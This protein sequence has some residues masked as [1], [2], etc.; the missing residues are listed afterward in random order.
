MAEITDPD[1]LAILETP[2]SQINKS[3]TLSDGQ[4]GIGSNEAKTR[5][6]QFASTPQLRGLLRDLGRA[7]LFNQRIPTG[8]WKAR[9][10][11]IGQEFPTDWQSNPQAI[12]D[13]QSFLG[14]RQG[15]AKPVIAL[16]APAGT[17]TSSKEMDTPKEL[18]LALTSVPGP[19]KEKGANEFLIN[20]TGVAALDKLAFN[21]FMDK[22]R[23]NFGSVYQKDRAGR[24]A[25]EAWQQYQASPQYRQTVTTPLTQLIE[26]NRSKV[27]AAPKRPTLPKGWG[28][29]VV[30]D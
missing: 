28:V 14:L 30:E 29:E 7:Q 5:E 19:E 12:A 25:S 10:S 21:S 1:I 6:A 3:V 11:E 2:Q 15:M 13:Y 9:V 24:T 22:W 4:S 17:T 26:R 23:A 27:R 18:E 20:R 8:R 16:T